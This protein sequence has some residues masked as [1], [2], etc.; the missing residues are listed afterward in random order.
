MFTVEDTREK[1]LIILQLIGRG[2]E[3]SIYPEFL[4]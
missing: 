2:K 3:R 1:E 4:I